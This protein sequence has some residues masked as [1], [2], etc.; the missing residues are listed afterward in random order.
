MELG[1]S[2][3]GIVIAVVAVGV[4]FWQGR[5]SKQQLDLARDSEGRTERALEEIR[6]L[7]RQN[8]DLV[9]EVKSDIDGRIN[10]FLDQQLSR[11]EQENASKALGDQMSNAMAEKFMGKIVEGMVAGLSPEDDGQ[12]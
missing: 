10:K 9:S 2:I 8:R 4:S 5:M 12:K 3:A 6:D 11:I 1:I 7:S